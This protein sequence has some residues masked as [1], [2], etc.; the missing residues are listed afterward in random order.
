MR[1]RRARSA[2]EQFGRRGLDGSTLTFV[3]PV[4]DGRS[5]SYVPPGS[6]S[7]PSGRCGLEPMPGHGACSARLCENVVN[8]CCVL[9]KTAMRPQTI[10]RPELS[11]PRQSRSY[12]ATTDALRHY[13]APWR[14]RR[15]TVKVYK[16][17][18]EYADAGPSRTRFGSPSTNHRLARPTR[19]GLPR[20]G[21]PQKSRTRAIFSVCASSRSSFEEATGTLLDVH[22][23]AGAAQLQSGDAARFRRLAGRHRG[24]VPRSPRRNC[25]ISSSDRAFRK[26]SASAATSIISSTGS[27]QRDRAALLRYGR[28]CINILYRNMVGLNLPMITIGL[29]QGDALGGGFESLLS[30]NVIVAEKGARFG[31]PETVFGL[32]PGMGAHAF[33]TRRLG[34]AQAERMILTGGIYTAEEMYALGHRPCPGRAGPGRAGGAG[35]HRPERAAPSRPSRPSMRRRAWSTRSRLARARSASSRSGPTRRST[36][37]ST[38]SR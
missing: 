5:A 12:P 24:P 25:A 10:L 33:L 14:G 9:G 27:A 38:T 21:A 11:L 22:A 4:S 6:A 34:A 13:R 16:S 35:L 37:G 31:L 15:P 3:P 2:L 29:V 8:T 7:S 26:S 18:T 17:L 36:F 32:F 19:P 23:S 28:A 20:I 30:F 1:R